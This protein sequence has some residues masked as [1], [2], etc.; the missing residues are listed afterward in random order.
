[1]LLFL[2]S[3]Q[4]SSHC[5]WRSAPPPPGRSCSYSLLPALRLPFPEEGAF[6][7]SGWRDNVAQRKQSLEN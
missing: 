7:L 2:I 4:S 5:L 6:F 3:L 1:M